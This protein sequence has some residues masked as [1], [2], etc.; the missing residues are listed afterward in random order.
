MPG[1]ALDH[2]GH[3]AV[4]CKYGED[5]VTQHNMI[6]DTH[7]RTCHQAFR[8]ADIGVKVEVSN[9]FS[10]DHSKTRPADILLLNWFLGQNCSIRCVHPPLNHVILLKAGVLTT[11]AAQAIESRKHHANDSKCSDLGWVCASMVVELC[12]KEATE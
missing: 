10:R 11:A 4:I 5:L 2:L 12:G 9:N 1:S 3:H 8:Q 7:W 6:R